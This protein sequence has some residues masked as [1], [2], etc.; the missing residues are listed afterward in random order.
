LDHGD[1]ARLTLARAAPKSGSRITYTYDFGDDWEHVIDV[2]AIIPAG[3]DLAY[4]R[5]TGGRRAAPPRT[6]AA[7]G[8]TRI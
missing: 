7:P 8:D 5:C 6:A 1:A 3:R 4:P 2:E